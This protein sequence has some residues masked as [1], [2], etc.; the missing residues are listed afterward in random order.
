[1]L[2]ADSPPS[3]SSQASTYDSALASDQRRTNISER[4]SVTARTLAGSKLSDQTHAVSVNSRFVLRGY[5][6]LMDAMRDFEAYHSP[7]SPLSE[8]LRL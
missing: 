4:R 5:K 7:L 2:E 1:M 8:A 6:S 3:W